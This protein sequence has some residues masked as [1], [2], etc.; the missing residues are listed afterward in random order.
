MGTVLA[1]QIKKAG[2]KPANPNY[3]E[4]INPTTSN[5]VYSLFSIFSNVN[6]ITPSGL[7]SKP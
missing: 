2:I 5:T 6:L 4:I 3:D 7:R 1:V